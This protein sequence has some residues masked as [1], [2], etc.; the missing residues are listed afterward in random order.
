[1][2]PA[3]FTTTVA[4]VRRAFVSV[5]RFDVFSMLLFGNMNFLANQLAI[6]LNKFRF[7][8]SANRLVIVMNPSC[9]PEFVGTDAHIDGSFFGQ[10]SAA[11]TDDFHFVFSC[12]LFCT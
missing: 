2:I 8:T 7:T 1:V 10:V 4:S 3:T 12:D 9:T 6:T 5:A 11:I